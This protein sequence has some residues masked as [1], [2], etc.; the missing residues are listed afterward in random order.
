MKNFIFRLSFPLNTCTAEVV[1]KTL[2]ISFHKLFGHSDQKQRC[3]V[4]TFVQ[5]I[6][7][8]GEK[9]SL[10]AFPLL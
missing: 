2:D 6:M 3:S 9:C 8:Q 10:L 4:F 5:Y 1:T 7:V